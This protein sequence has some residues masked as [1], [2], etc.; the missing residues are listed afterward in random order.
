MSAVL[1]RELR[2][3]DASG[4]DD[5]VRSLPYFFGVE[6]GV[7]ACA[8]AVRTQPGWVAEV[9]GEVHGF[10]V[11]EYPL[12]SAPE[13]SWMAVRAGW[14][15]R[16]L[17]RALIDRA[18]QELAGAGADVLSVLTLAPSVPETGSDT[19]A[20][21]RAFYVSNGFRPIR[22]IQPPGWNSSALLLARAL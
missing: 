5:I 7:V 8:E 19:Y 13:I 18:A 10:L 2:L 1:V 20:G 21:T 9:S 22:E 4:C 11:V 14:R 15:R 3:D 6:A 12:P 17:G 16:G